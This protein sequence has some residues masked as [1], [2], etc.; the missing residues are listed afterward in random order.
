MCQ[1]TPSPIRLL[2]IWVQCLFYNIITFLSVQYDLIGISMDK[3]IIF[4]LGIYIIQIHPLVYRRVFNS[5]FYKYLAL[6]EYLLDA[7][8]VVVGVLIQDA[9]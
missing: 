3:N 9:Y 1:R 6:K 7:L 5:K 8:L 2:K 4:S